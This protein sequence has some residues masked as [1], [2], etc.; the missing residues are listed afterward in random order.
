M[1]HDIVD[2]HTTVKAS[3][4]P[5]FMACRIPLQSQL[6]IINWKKYLVNYWDQ[7][8]VD[9]LAFGFPLDFDRSRP[10]QATEIN[11]AS[12][13]AYSQH[14]DKYLQDEIRF[15]AIYG[16]FESKPFPLHVSPFMTSEK[17][18]TSKRRAIVD[19]SW[20]HG[21]SV[22]AGV[23]K[24]KSWVPIL[25]SGTLPLILLYKQLKRSVLRLLCSR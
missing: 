19:L 9:L 1:I 15:G 22:N 11:H 7:Q 24:H 17:S 21:L 25:N 13:I 18:G 12:A 6:N 4:L 16:P 2:L 14:I 20:P 3:N 23:A 5:N 8:L 10:L